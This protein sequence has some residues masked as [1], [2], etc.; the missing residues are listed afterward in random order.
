MINEIDYNKIT[1]A[2]YTRGGLFDDK[3]NINNPNDVTVKYDELVALRKLALKGY[4]I[5]LIDDVFFPV[6]DNIKQSI[7][8]W[9]GVLKGLEN[10]IK[11]YRI[12]D[13][14]QLYVKLE[15]LNSNGNYCLY[16]GGRVD[17][18]YPLTEKCLI[19][20][21]KEDL[22]TFLMREFNNVDII[23]DLFMN[24]LTLNPFPIESLNQVSP[25]VSLKSWLDKN[26][27]NYIS[28]NTKNSDIQNE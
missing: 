6:C 20:F 24:G 4:N 26:I 16:V 27:E 10:K 11:F 19:G 13:E 12:K 5:L 8:L 18:Y 3:F 14:L 17:D 7:Y 25:I 1:I 15:E 21:I 2:I 23:K 9:N 22:H 28:I